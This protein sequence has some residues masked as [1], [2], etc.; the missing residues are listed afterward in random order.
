MTAASFPHPP[1]VNVLLPRVSWRRD[2]LLVVGASLVMALLTHVKVPLPFTPV[3]ITGQTL[4]AMLIGL[5]LG[6]RLGFLAIL[7]YLIE[8]TLGL[9]VFAG[10]SAAVPSG[11]GVLLGPTG[12][13]LLAFPLAAAAMGLA[14]ERFRA[15]QRIWTLA[16]AM[17]VGNI[18]IYGL[19]LA[20]LG[21][22]L[23][24]Q[25]KYAGFMALLNAGLIPFI[26]GDLIKMGL[27]SG[28][29]P[30]V[31]KAVAKVD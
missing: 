27:C 8:G 21:V 5:V 31:R 11:V 16:L 22:W 17:L 10:A 1:L 3:P 26:P 20:W 13:Y 7:L 6:S 4:G 2:V 24:E 23:S 18:I 29:L 15:D 14:V 12:G 30:F 19:G 28:S 9:P 25:N